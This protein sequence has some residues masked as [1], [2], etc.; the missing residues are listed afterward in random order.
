MFRQCN[1]NNQYNNSY[2]PVDYDDNMY[3][4]ND[5]MYEQMCHMESSLENEN[6]SPCNCGYNSSNVFS[7]TLLYASSYVPHQYMNKVYTPE[8]GL[9]MGTIFPELLSPYCPG[10]SQEIMN[11]LK[12]SRDYEGGCNTN[13]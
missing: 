2:M 3:N 5:D 10:Q 1:C 11:Y 6:N 12:D 13:G 7:N 8:T 4:N 9:K